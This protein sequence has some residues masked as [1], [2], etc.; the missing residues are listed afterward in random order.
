VKIVEHHHDRRVLRRQHRCEPEQEC[1]VVGVLIGGRRRDP[2]NGD[3]Y[4]PQGRHEI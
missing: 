3:A 4:T 1:M 2:R